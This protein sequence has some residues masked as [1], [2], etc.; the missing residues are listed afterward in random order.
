MRIRFKPILI[1]VCFSFSFFSPKGAISGEDFCPEEPS[2]VFEM[3]EDLVLGVGGDESNEIFGRLFDIKVNSRGDVYILDNGFNVIQ[4]YNENGKY[5]G[6]IGG[7]GEG[8]GYFSFP[9]AIAIDESDN[10]YVGDI[11][12]ITVFDSDGD[13]SKII[14]RRHPGTII[15]SMTASSEDGV[16]I[17]AF[18]VFDQ[19]VLHKYST[20]HFYEKSFCHSYA[21]DRDVDV[22]AERVFAGGAIDH[23]P[24]GIVFTQAYPYEIR[25]FNCF[26]ELQQ[27]CQIES[28]YMLNPVFNV[29]GEKIEIGLR[30]AS[31]SIVSMG[32]QGY[33]NTVI[34]LPP[35]SGKVGCSRIDWFNK[36]LKLIGG[37]TYSGRLEIKCKDDQG[38]LWAIVDKDIPLVVRYDWFPQLDKTAN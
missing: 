28:D 1:F 22:R 19:A 2:T 4:K 13:Y 20:N 9:T 35:E 32:D 23:F 30:S 18:S 7:Q 12:R 37:Q 14:E 6:S 11:G 25:I 33:L 31:Y 27:S 15:K 24:G 8:P 10:L 38:R 36:D 3:T 21:Y 16:F 34:V 26:G 29:K 17:V 5:L